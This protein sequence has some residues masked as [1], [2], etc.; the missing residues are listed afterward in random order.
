MMTLLLGRAVTADL[1]VILRNVYV[2]FLFLP[3]LC[4]HRQSL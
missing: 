2:V 1:D 4:L 3:V